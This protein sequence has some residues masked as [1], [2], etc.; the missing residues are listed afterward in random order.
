MNTFPA[1]GLENKESRGAWLN[2]T[3]GALAAGTAGAAQTLSKMAQRGKDVS[4]GILYTVKGAQYGTFG[5][6]T[7]G[8]GE[9]IYAIGK[10]LHNGES[11]TTGEIAQLSSMLFLWTHSAKNLNL[12]ESVMKISETKNTMATK[13]FLLSTQ[14]TVNSLVNVHKTIMDR[15][16]NPQMMINVVKEC[17]EMIMEG[18]AYI[19]QIGVSYS[20]PNCEFKYGTG[21]DMLATTKIEYCRVFDTRMEAIVSTINRKYKCN[22]ITVVKKLLIKYMSSA[23][24]LTLKGVDN[25]INYALRT[26]KNLVHEVGLKSEELDRLLAHIF[27][28]IKQRVKIT[29]MSVNKYLEALNRG[30]ELY[31][32]EIRHMDAD[33]RQ[34]IEDGTNSV[35]DMDI[36]DINAPEDDIVNEDKKLELAL[37]D[38]AEDIMI[39]FSEFEN[40]DRTTVLE[41]TIGSIII[42]LTCDSADVFFNIV[43]RLVRKHNESIQE[44]LALDE[45]IPIDNFITVIYF[46]LL[47]RSESTS[48]EIL[49]AEYNEDMHAE[50]DEEFRAIYQTVTTADKIVDCKKC[51]GKTCSQ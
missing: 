17:P 43:E 30:N 11:I 13:R 49:L 16:V 36:D 22:D 24:N 47:M 32:Y 28:L 23:Y 26:F 42:D 50:I 40:K 35:A 44:T 18:V 20:Q 37:K 38:R 31:R 14:K 15:L 12:G 39:R 5:I 1:I 7:I 33:V 25:L 29:P 48:M 6:Q 10:K 4:R 27:H 9:G 2:I 46:L 3:T 51:A 45:S 41:E 8:C 19:R 21:G 34:M